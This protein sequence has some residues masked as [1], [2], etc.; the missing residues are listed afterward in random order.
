LTLD[1]LI[2]LPQRLRH[3][4]PGRA[5]RAEGTARPVRRAHPAA[6]RRQ[7]HRRGPRLPRRAHRRPRLV[8]GQART[9][10]HQPRLPR[11]A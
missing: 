11:P 8:P 7:D 6:L 9:W 2:H 5:R 1:D 3:P 10:L 4:V